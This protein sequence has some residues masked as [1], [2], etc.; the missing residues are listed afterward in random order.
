MRVASTSVTGVAASPWLPLDHYTEGYGDG[1]FVKPGAG[2]TVSVEATADDVF[3]PNVTPTAFPVGVAALTGATTNVA[4]ALPFAAKA[5][6]LNQSVGV[7]T[8]TLQVV[9]RGNT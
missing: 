2:A 1:V 5:I 4:A 7:S 8:S 3:N 6:R 9:V